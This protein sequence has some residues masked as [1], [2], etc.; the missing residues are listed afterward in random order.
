MSTCLLC[1]SHLRE[2]PSFLD[3]FLSRQT[4]HRLCQS[5]F[6]QFEVISDLHCQYCYKPEISGICL[7]CEKGA[8]I[9]L[10]RAIFHYNEAAKTYF[11]RYKF[12]GD[13]RLRSAFDQSLRIA[14]KH[15]HIIPIPISDNRLHTRGFNQVTGFLNSAGLT[16]LDV[17]GK[18]DT[19]HQSHKTRLER[20]TSTNPFY[21]N[22]PIK[23]PDQVV[24]FDDIYT[25][26]TTLHHAREIIE[27]AG[28]TRISTFS[29]FR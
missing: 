2:T 5:C 12:Q 24:I 4:Q 7:D 19:D 15:T 10:H 26:G 1:A 23:L 6:A 29:L 16:Y 14:L 27:K 9:T 21:L 22:A 18:K 28:C 25:T 17:L 13:F 8:N 11:K 20:L 3:F